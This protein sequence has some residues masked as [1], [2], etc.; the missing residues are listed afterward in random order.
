MIIDDSVGARGDGKLVI[1]EDE[2]VEDEE[3]VKGPA[4]VEEVPVVVEAPADVEEVPVVVEA[5]ADV[6]KVPVVVEDPVVVE[7]AALRRFGLNV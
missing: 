2:T 3:A 7:E 4:V 5:P 6:E 1:D